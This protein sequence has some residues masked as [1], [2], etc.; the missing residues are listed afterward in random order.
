MLSFWFR[1]RIFFFLRKAIRPFV[2]YN[3]EL[4][5]S[6]SLKELQ[7]SNIF[8]VIPE[9]SISDLIA[10][11]FCCSEL[12]ILSPMSPISTIQKHRFTYLRLP[13]FNRKEQKIKRSNAKNLEKVINLDQIK[14]Q[15]IPVSFYWGKHPDKQ[16]SFFKILFSQSW[17]VSSPLK[18]IFRILFHGRSLTIQFQ[19]SLDL[20]KLLDKKKTSVENS[21]ILSRYLRVLFKRSKKAF[22]GPDISHRS[23]LVNTLS[24]DIEVRKEI[25]KLSSGNPKIKRKLNNK[26]R[27]YANEICSDLNYPIV[28]NLVRGFTWFWNNRYD[29]IH[30]KNLE[31]IKDLSKDNSLIFVP[32]HKSHIDYCAL[33]YIL[34]E[35]G[36][37]LPQVAAG[38]N[39]NIPVVGRLLRG[40]GAIFMR[41]SFTKNTLYSTVFFQHIRGL[42]RRGNSIEFFPE[43]GRSRSGLTLPARP[44]LISMILRSFASLKT[45]K[46]RIVPVYIGYE[47]ILEGET[48]RSEVLGKPKRGESMLDALKVLKDFNNYLGN[49][50][51]N[52]GDPIDLENFLTNEL[53]NKNFHINSPLERPPWLQDMTSRLGETIMQNINSSVAVTTTSL[54]A[55]ALLTENTQSLDKKKLLS[56]IETYLELLKNLDSYQDIWIPIEKPSKIIAKTIELKFVKEQLIGSTTIFKPTPNEI[57][58]LSFYKNNISHLFI[59]YSA[60]CESL[61]Y[62]KALNKDEVSRLV[63]LVY[64]F[65]K[66][67]FNLQENEDLSLIIDNSL[68]TLTNLKLIEINN[69]HEVNKPNKNSVK[70]SDYLA[71]CNICEPSI[72]RFYIIMQVLWSNDLIKKDKLK[73]VCIGIAINLEKSEGWSYPEF[74]DKTKFDQFLDKML[75]E[76]LIRQNEEGYLKASKIT[77]KVKK[78]FLNFFDKRF[79]ENIK[80]YH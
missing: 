54:F 28:R 77:Q 64:P 73:E 35:N 56:R 15:L 39:L 60:I 17:R 69:K 47:K 61:R 76:K 23:T 66:R 8:F 5:S 12:K 49:A 32:C 14:L 74:S 51:I 34:I 37:M 3:I 63:L 80:T 11:D 29:G 79:I 36:M 24:T 58:L 27:K 9:P 13:K 41:R 30:I 75:K 67:D 31:R 53:D 4:D 70:Y 10:L 21:R 65:L 1:K 55:T 52:F 50:Y 71:L 68:N 40:A 48:Y 44:G 38:N 18:K 7:N 20:N 59:V 33:S 72:K 42:L 6:L 16:K 43:G 2:R 46:V 22:L 19:M 25:N 57:A 62:S 78:D 26:A 45:N